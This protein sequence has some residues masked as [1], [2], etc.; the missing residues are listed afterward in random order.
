MN[1]RCPGFR[2]SFILVVLALVPACGSNPFVDSE[3]MLPADNPSG[4]I[5]V[6]REPGGMVCVTEAGSDGE[7]LRTC[8]PE[9]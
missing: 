4:D 6:E 9:V 7:P 3:V 1:F 5:E 8:V 2:V